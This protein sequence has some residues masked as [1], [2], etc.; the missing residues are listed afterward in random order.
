MNERRKSR[1]LARI[2]GQL[3]FIDLRPQARARHERR[4]DEAV[5]RLRGLL[6]DRKERRR[7]EHLETLLSY[8]RDD[9]QPADTCVHWRLLARV[10]CLVWQMHLRHE[11][12]AH[13]AAA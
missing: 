11:S 12:P 4:V 8:S 1:L 5:T 7:L 10:D 6:G 9:G 3:A 2:E 13:E